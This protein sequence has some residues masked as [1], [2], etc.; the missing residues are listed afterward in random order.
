M[1]YSR[2]AVLS[3][4]FIVVCSSLGGA[5]L[6]EQKNSL[7]TN[8]SWESTKISM[9]KG[10]VGAVA[11]FTTRTTLA[12]HKLD[13][14]AWHGYN[15]LMLKK[16]IQPL[17][18]NFTLEL[19]YPAD[20]TFIFDSDAKGFKGVRLSRNKRLN[21]EYIEADQKGNILNRQ[22]LNTAFNLAKKSTIQLKFENSELIVNINGEIEKLKVEATQLKQVG[23]RSQSKKSVIIDD[24]RIVDLNS[25]VF[26]ET[27]TPPNLIFNSLII[28]FILCASLALLLL[29][30]K[31]KMFVFLWFNLVLF[32]ASFV[33][34]LLYWADF[35]YFSKQYPEKPTAIDRLLRG[36]DVS[37]FKNNI[38]YDDQVLSRVR[39]QFDA[40]QS[41]QYRILLVGSS[42]T[43]GSG[44]ETEGE[45]FEIYLRDIFRK[46]KNKKDL[47]VINTAVP[48]IRIE[49]MANFI[50]NLDSYR[51]DEVILN[52][53]H[54]D[55]FIEDF[56]LNLERLI[57]YCQRKKIKITLLLEANFFAD[58]NPNLMRNHQA[59][60]EAGRAHKINVID[61]HEKLNLIA[62]Q[63]YYW[64]DNVHLTS[65]GQ[66]IAA[67]TVGAKYK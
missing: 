6:A 35:K 52:S 7:Y 57:N 9:Q 12:G 10:L 40:L 64:W 61:L 53:S 1:I 54:N 27:F 24:L 62:D 3:L 58:L 21:N 25:Q 26:E 32:N 63:G 56:K 31:N 18:V 28:V 15:Q 20:V 50:E 48:G 37:V 13:L 60:R 33:I 45:Q 29:I 39:Q 4:I 41:S 49:K 47:A 66:K 8:G 43:W 14:G 16:K 19:E 30:F 34:A 17:E 65:E 44:A 5:F 22:I 46:I 23:F 51:I 67:E 2:F 59:L 38:E 36:V 11:F 55:Y 42:Q